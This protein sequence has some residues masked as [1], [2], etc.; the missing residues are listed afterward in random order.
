MGA[1]ATRIDH[2]SLLTNVVIQP[3]AFLGGVFYS[4]D[5]L[6]PVLRT[7]TLLNPI[8]HTVD[9][10]A[11]YA[12]LQTSDL[13]PYPA[14]A[15]VVL[16]AILSFQ[17]SVVGDSPWPESP[18]LD[19]ATEASPPPLGRLSSRSS[20]PRACS[21]SVAGSPGTSLLARGASPQEVA[22]GARRAS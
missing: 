3:L 7:A 19:D 17:R 4:V 8:F 12:T 16:L 22:V 13:N 6:P 20:P 5:M 10:A 21:F 2:I 15:V 9:A 11:R 1:L 14:L 18:L